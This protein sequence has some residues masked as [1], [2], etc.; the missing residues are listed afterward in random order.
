M[1]IRVKTRGEIS[2]V[3]SIGARKDRRREQEGKYNSSAAAASTLLSKQHAAGPYD[4]H[5]HT[6]TA[7][8]GIRLRDGIGN[9]RHERVCVYVCVCGGGVGQLYKINRFL[10][11]F[12]LSAG[13]RKAFTTPR[14][15]VSGRWPPRDES[16][17]N[18]CARRPIGTNRGTRYII[19]DR[20]TSVVCT[21]ITE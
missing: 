6:H 16:A 9:G 4:T 20:P 8:R 5:T 19:T 7:R 2:L 1:S 13:N 21:E 18:R 12:A 14:R 11:G 15:P 10:E 17:S 3:R